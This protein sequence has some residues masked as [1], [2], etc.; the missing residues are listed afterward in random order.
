MEDEDPQPHLTWQTREI[1]SGAKV[2]KNLKTLKNSFRH[3]LY[4]L[5]QAGSAGGPAASTSATHR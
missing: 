1:V 5:D 4:V 3:L 2:Q